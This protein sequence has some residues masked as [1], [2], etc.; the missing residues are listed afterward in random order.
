[1][2]TSHVT[3]SVNAQDNYTKGVAE[4]EQ[5]NWAAAAKYFS[6]IRSRFPYSTFA[7]LA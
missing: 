4:L 7:V 3:Y 1:M 2:S 5:T 6:F